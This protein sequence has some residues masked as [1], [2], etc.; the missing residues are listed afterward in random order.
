MPA[1]RAVAVWAR[2]IPAPLYPLQEIDL[3]SRHLKV[4]L[5]TTYVG[6]SGKKKAWLSYQTQLHA[7]LAQAWSTSQSTRLIARTPSRPRHGQRIGPFHGSPPFRQRVS[8]IK[9]DLAD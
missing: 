5:R 4:D 1:P 7:K 2:L 8:E 6:Y 9:Q 3:R